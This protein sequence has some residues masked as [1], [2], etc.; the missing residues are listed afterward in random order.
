[1]ST[2]V[3]RSIVM[4][5]GVSGPGAPA[6]RSESLPQPDDL[7]LVDGA[8]GTATERRVVGAVEGRDVAPPD[9]ATQSRR[10]WKFCTVVPVPMVTGHLDGVEATT[11][12]GDLRVGAHDQVRIE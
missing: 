11:G 4:D 12:N 2:A 5:F 3:G 7:R 6:T 8:P 1:M 10:R 9:A